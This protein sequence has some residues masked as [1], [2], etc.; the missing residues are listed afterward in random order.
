MVNMIDADFKKAV[1]TIKENNPKMD[2]IDCFIEKFNDYLDDNKKSS[3]FLDVLNDID[4]RC[5][6]I[7]LF[8]NYHYQ[9]NNGGHSQYFDNGYASSEDINKGFFGNKTDDCD[10]HKEMIQLFKKYLPKNE[11][12]IAFINNLEQFTVSIQEEDCDCCDGNGYCEEECCECNG[13]GWNDEEDCECEECDGRGVIED[14][15]W[16]CNG[17]GVISNSFTVVDDDFLDK[18]YYD[19]EDDVLELFNSVVKSWLYSDSDCQ[20]NE[21]D[22]SANSSKIENKKSKL[23]LVGTDGNAFAIMGKVIEALRKQNVSKDVVE[24]YKKDAMSGDY[25]K[26]LATSFKYCENANIEVC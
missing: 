22:G 18:K 17:E 14:E 15:C 21:L 12:T 4:E 24:Q 1:L 25:N 16:N 23:K 2:Y 8:G 13:S 6:L 9:V 19:I 26:L 20:L 10:L 3:D 7:R 5:L 11:I